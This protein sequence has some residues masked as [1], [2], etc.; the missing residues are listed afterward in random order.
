MWFECPHRARIPGGKRTE[1]GS[2]VSSRLVPEGYISAAAAARRIGISPRAVREAVDER[3]LEGMRL[4]P[5]PRGPIVVLESSVDTFGAARGSW[6]TDSLSPGLMHDLQ[7]AEER[8]EGER[9][10]RLETL[11]EFR[12]SE[13]DAALRDVERLTTENERLRV[14]IAALVGA[15]L[16][17]T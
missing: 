11:V 9:L 17:S 16:P 2:D 7:R 13:R 4:G 15:Q 8:I 6:A 12:T 10:G 5:P 3:R 1:A 14:S